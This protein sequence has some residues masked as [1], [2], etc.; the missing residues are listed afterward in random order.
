M[1]GRVRAVPRQA[2]VITKYGSGWLTNDGGTRGVNCHCQPTSPS[3]S[4]PIYRFGFKWLRRSFR[5][6]REGWIK[7]AS[8]RIGSSPARAARARPLA[9]PRPRARTRWK[10]NLSSVIS[11]NGIHAA[12]VIFIFFHST[13]L[14]ART[15]ARTHAWTDGLTDGRG[16]TPHSLQSLAL[17]RFLGASSRS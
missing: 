2:R 5:W 15:H 16:Q 7:E 9:R 6:K 8:P 1:G 13:T 17:A 11:L 10:W 3:L 12:A 14:N 4:Y